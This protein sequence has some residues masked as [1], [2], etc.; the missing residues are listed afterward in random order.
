VFLPAS[1]FRFSREDAI[2]SGRHQVA[3]AVTV[4]NI[5]FHAK[6]SRPPVPP[7]LTAQLHSLPA[8]SITTSSWMQ[9]RESSQK[10]TL[11]NQNIR[12]LAF[13]IPYQS[14]HHS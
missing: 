4:G 8:L 2:G 11:Y 12:L 7:K 6:T 5:W 10:Y 1:T 14:L 3:R 13:T 9:R